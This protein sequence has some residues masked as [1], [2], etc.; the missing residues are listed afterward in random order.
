MR[1]SQVAFANVTDTKSVAPQ[2]HAMPPVKECQQ[3]MKLFFKKL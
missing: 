1:L 3:Q 2:L